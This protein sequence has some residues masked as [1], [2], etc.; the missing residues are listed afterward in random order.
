MGGTWEK[1]RGGASRA[2]SGDGVLVLAISGRVIEERRLEGIER[3]W[4]EDAFGGGERQV[5]S[6]K[7]RGEEVEERETE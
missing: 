7:E 3:G 5:E 1:N 6:E 4:S 2:K